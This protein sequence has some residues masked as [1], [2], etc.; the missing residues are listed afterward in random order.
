MSFCG[1]GKGDWVI[2]LVWQMLATR[3]ARC[4]HIGPPPPAIATWNK[5]QFWKILS[6][7]LFK[8]FT[9]HHPSLF[10]FFQLQPS[11]LPLHISYYPLFLLFLWIVFWMISL[12]LSP[13]PLAVLSSTGCIWGS[14]VHCIFIWVKH[15]P[16]LDILLH[17]FQS[18]EMLLVVS[19]LLIIFSG[20][21][22]KIA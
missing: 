7:H 2:W 18:C 5:K 22:S 17:F 16:F 8:I 1:T 19:S 14:D 10:F 13:A 4:S 11:H 20:F 15:F 6:N 9:V 12:F 21:F 3:M